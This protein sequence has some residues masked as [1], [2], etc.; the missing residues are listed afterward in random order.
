MIT[1][2]IFD[3]DLPPEEKDGIAV[4]LLQCRISNYRPPVS[5][6][7]KRNGYPIFSCVVKL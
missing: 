2:D 7:R 4:S 6:K 3:V 5:V 1:L